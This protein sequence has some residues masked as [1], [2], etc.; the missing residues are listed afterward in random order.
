MKLA[1]LG[2]LLIVVTPTFAQD[3]TGKSQTEQAS[4]PGE[5]ADGQ[6]PTVEELIKL[7]ADRLVELQEKDGAWPYEGVYR[8]R[9][10]I[11]FGYRVGGTAIVCTSLMYASDDEAATQAIERGVDIML[12]D[13]EHPL[14]KADMANAYDVRVWGHIYSLDLF[15]RI[16]SSDRFA[17]LRKRTDPWI[18]KLIQILATEQTADGGWNYAGQQRHA[19]FVT[20]PA[21]QALLLAK[22][23][24]EDVSDEMLVKAR[25]ALLS[26]RSKNGAFR[27]SGPASPRRL[28]P[29]PGSIARSA[30]CESTLILLGDGGVDHVRDA[31][32][33]FHKH[34]DELE[35]R[36]KKNGTHEAPYGIAPY[37]FYYAHRYIGQAIRFLPK[38][39]QA[40]E[41]EK[42]KAVLL[43]TKD[44]DNT[45]NDRVFDRSRAYGTAMS[46]LA[47]L[48]NV[49][50]PNTIRS[51]AN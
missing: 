49:A 32:A 50:V 6:T 18:S 17:E 36:R 44:A 25:K 34:W 41:L 33:A 16:R 23:Q 1:S 20:S 38:E 11:P 22:Q 5:K 3:A 4:E 47:L 30:V 37:Y 29:L 12:K 19:S 39:E 15:C 24:G 2:I 27:Y 43:R 21:I 35:K 48:N 8:V 46:I 10:R 40:V 13:L 51:S 28:T 45:W 42:F 9:R 26:S 7:A 31:I 14:M